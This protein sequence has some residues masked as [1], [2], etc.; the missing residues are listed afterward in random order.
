ML[1]TKIREVNRDG[2]G[3]VEYIAGPISKSHCIKNLSEKLEYSI[4]SRFTFIPISSHCSFNGPSLIVS[5]Y[6]P[7]WRTHGIVM[8][9][10][11]EK[12]KKYDPTNSDMLN[13]VKKLELSNGITKRWSE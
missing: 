6:G 10:S 3:P 5:R 11:I 7:D 8:T 13:F 2:T 1:D 12:M 9:T 4:L